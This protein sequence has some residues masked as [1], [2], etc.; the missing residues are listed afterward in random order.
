VRVKVEDR[1][2][3]AAAGA[4]LISLDAF[5]GITMAGMTIVNNPG[6]WS[7]MYWPLEHADWNGWTPTDLIFP[8]FLFIVGV[9]MTLSRQT[10]GAPW[11]RIVRRALV[12]I[13]LG[14][15][16][17]GFPHFNPAHW[18][19]PGV[20]VRIGVCYLVAAFVFRWS[21]HRR[22]VVVLSAVIVALLV[23]YWYGL[24]HF[25]DLTPAGNIGARIDRALFGGHL[26][27]R[28]WD[29]EG[30][31]SSAPA[32]ATTL[33]GA[34]AGLW[35]QSS[36]APVRRV[37]ALAGAGVVLFGA[38]MVWGV[39]FPI[40]KNL[41]TSSY[42][43]LTGGAAAMCLA[44]C[45]YFIDIRRFTMWSRPFVVLGSNAIVLFVLSG[46]LAKLGI[47]I[48]VAGAD[49]ARVSLQSV[50]YERGFEWMGS[51]KNAS[52]IFSLVFLGV[53]YAVCHEL[54]RRHI[55]LKA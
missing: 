42:V 46:F 37:L 19:I 27:R 25:G 15:L 53:M 11:W 32:V 52:L 39:S 54:Y 6:T 34:L 21:A 49:G 45:I 4:R 1:G 31:L 5:R 20:L 47:I 12:I 51:P 10:L 23:G 28:D 7:A 3:A 48:K 44:A 43:L 55:F 14:A 26:W 38:G 36:A 24:T 33:L 9:S 40:N 41:W 35:M 30:L 2:A 18:R 8:F 13:G 17:A 16:L 29:P 50:I 22:Q